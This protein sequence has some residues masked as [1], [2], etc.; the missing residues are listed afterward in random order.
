MQL[1]FFNPKNMHKNKVGLIVGSFMGLF[2]L[3][4]SVLVATGVA[5]VL[6]NWIYKLHF[7]NNPFIVGPFSVKIA[8][9]LV[10]VTFVV[11]YVAGWFFVFL[12]NLAHKK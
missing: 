3:L 11:G 4:W 6:I 12:W 7:L 9:A 10:A 8:A 2:H 5:Q 1:I